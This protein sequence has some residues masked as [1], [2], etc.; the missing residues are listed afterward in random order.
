M[1]TLSL[2]ELLTLNNNTSHISA[3]EVLQNRVDCK[4]PINNLYQIKI[5]E[6]YQ[7]TK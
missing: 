2:I 5:I 6:K 3:C 7:S 1:E 4:I